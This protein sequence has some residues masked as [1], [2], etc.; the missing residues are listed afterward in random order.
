LG[1][2]TRITVSTLG[3]YAGLLGAAHRFF[4]ILQGNAAPDG[5]MI[6]AIGAP[7][8]ADA[9]W[10]ACLPAITLMPNFRAAG[11][12]TIILAMSVLIVATVFIR[13]KRGGV[14]LI[15]FSVLMLLAGGG[16]VPT[17]VGIVAGVAG[18]GIDARLTR[19][20][21]RPAGNIGR[22]LAQ[23]WSW[24][25]AAFVAWSLGG[26]IVGQFFN[27]LMMRLSFFLFFVFD[28]GLPVLAAVAANVRDVERRA[29]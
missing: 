14:I 24:I 1:T 8:Q 17:F 27:Q 12:S 9:V 25:L 5:A 26:W 2:A 18:A 15:L 7:C 6:N 3:A 11:I 19:W 22:F 20:Q 4:E 21:G 23:A 29:T 28:L 16:F 10:H 13:H